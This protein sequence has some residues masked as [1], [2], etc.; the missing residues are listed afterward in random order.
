MRTALLAL[1]GAAALAAQQYRAFW[2]DAFHPGAK[3]PAQIEQ[4]V[5]DLTTAKANAV[6]A[7]MRPRGNWL[8]PHPVEPF[9]SDSQYAPGFDALQY[10]IERAHARGIEVHA[11]ANVTSVG[12]ST[13]PRHLTAAHGPAAEEEEMW[14]TVSSAGR[15]SP[16]SIDLGHP[17]ALRHTADVILDAARY[18]LDGI[19]MDYVRYPEDAD[20]GWNPVAVERFQ[21]LWNR[22]GKPDPRDPAWAEFRRTQVTQFVRQLYL[23]AFAIR[24]SIRISAAS[25][26]W[27]SGPADDAGYRRLDAYSR[28][29]QDWRGWLEEGILDFA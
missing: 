23:R 11:W 24:P 25:V 14:M 6:I 8:Y 20:Y 18:G 5:D 21:R 15:I 16:S 4:L 28:V 9:Y 1:A 17:G 10:L 2:A 3:T 13:D 29:F 27:G 26:T 12:T 19:H 22:A 7:Q